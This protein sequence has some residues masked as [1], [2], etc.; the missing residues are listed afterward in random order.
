[1]ESVVL[2]IIQ[3]LLMCLLFK[4]IIV[5]VAAAVNSTAFA[6]VVNAAINS[7]AI[8]TLT[9][10]FQIKTLISLR[11]PKAQVLQALYFGSVQGPPRIW[12]ALQKITKSCPLT[13]IPL[14]RLP[15]YHVPFYS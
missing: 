4:V 7:T 5:V 6:I 14:S 1:M 9:H 13:Y 2:I 10:C 15:V 8:A 11:I 3:A 12:P